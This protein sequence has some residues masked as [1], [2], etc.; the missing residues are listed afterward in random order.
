MMDHKYLFSSF[1]VIMCG[2][3]TNKK[4]REV[5]KQCKTHM[6]LTANT[7]RTVQNVKLPF[8]QQFF[9]HFSEC[10]TL[11]QIHFKVQLGHQ[12]K[13]NPNSTKMFRSII[14]NFFKYN[15]KT[16]LHMCICLQ[17]WL[18]HISGL[19]PPCKANVMQF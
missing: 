7:H 14:S 2:R 10:I 5:E 16:Y 18:L 19:H 9:H 6:H 12:V 1:K 15:L 17:L 11:N 8:T 13:Y 3:W 4:E